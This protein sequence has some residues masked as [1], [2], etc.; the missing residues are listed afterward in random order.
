[1]RILRRLVMAWY[2]RLSGIAE[3]ENGV[4]PPWDG[5]AVQT[6]S[7]PWDVKHAKGDGQV[8]AIFVTLARN[9]D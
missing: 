3:G 4:E 6:V 7:S 1:M 5:F 9:L 8:S 2:R